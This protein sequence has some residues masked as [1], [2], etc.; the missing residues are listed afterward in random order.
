MPG[1]NAILD[2]LE[3]LVTDIMTAF[4]PGVLPPADKLSQR[5]REE[6]EAL[7]KGPLKKGG[8]HLYTVAYPP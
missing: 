4:P 8:K 2:Y 7:L 1:V 6:I 5:G 3:K